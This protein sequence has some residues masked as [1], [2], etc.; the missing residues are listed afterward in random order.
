[1]RVIEASRLAGEVE[2]LCLEVSTA[3]PADA[4]EALIRYRALEESDAGRSLIDLILQNAAAAAELGVPLCQDTG[5]FTIY[6]TLAAG[7]ALAGDVVR[8]AG[9]AVA[10][11][12][13]RG[14]LRPSV[15]ADPIGGRVNTGD[16]TPPLVEVEF[17]Q[18]EESTLGVMAKGGGSETASRLAMMPPG[19]GWNGALE[20]IVGTVEALGAGACP[21]LVLGVGI[22][23]S[24]DRAP[25]LAKKALMIPLDVEA[26]DPASRDR[27]AELIERVNRLGIGPGGHGGSVTCFGARII[28]APCHMANLPVALSVNCHALR[29]KTIPI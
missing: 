24:F 27:E 19:A 18:G 29:R 26:P 11:A 4:A 28:E 20:F 1:M 10:R 3:F 23:G 7:T 25:K 17:S 13:V 14:A 8:E 22:G 16:N 9:D 6:L 15:V 12:T 5:I 21:P 2:A